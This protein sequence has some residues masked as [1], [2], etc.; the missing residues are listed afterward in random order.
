MGRPVPRGPT[1][2][3]RVCAEMPLFLMFAAS[4]R[5]RR[6]WAGCGAPDGPVFAPWGR[7]LPSADW[8]HGPSPKLPSLTSFVVVKQSATV[9]SRSALRARAMNPA[10]S[11]APSLLALHSPPTRAFAETTVRSP[12]ANP[13]CV[14][15]TP[16]WHPG[17]EHTPVAGRVRGTGLGAISGATKKIGFGGG[18]RSTLRGLTHRHC[19]TTTNEVS[20]GSLAMHPRSRASSWSRPAR[21][22]RPSMSPQPSPSDA[23][24]AHHKKKPERTLCSLE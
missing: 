7:R 12:D 17:Y 1:R 13:G 4:A 19:L 20:G 11:G 8:L 16:D 21:A 24:R 23:P 2:V 6:G 3:W 18:V 15:Q 14:G 10:S 9:S 5:Q 22:D